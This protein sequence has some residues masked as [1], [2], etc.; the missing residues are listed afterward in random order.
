MIDETLPEVVK[1]YLRAGHRLE[2]IALD[3]FGRWTHEGI[4]F[5]N[6]RV[7]DLFSRSV[8]RTDGGTWVLVIP[9]FTYPIEVERTGYFVTGVDPE[10]GTIELSDG[11][12]ELLDVSTLDYE[13]E[14]C[15]YCKV[16]GGE[17]EA[18]FLRNPYYA[19]ADRLEDHDG[20]IQLRWR[21]ELLDASWALKAQS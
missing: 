8:Q 5:E 14:G 10:V 11:T 19:L 1:S 20:T 6:P 7:I 4:D 21:A 16:K 13:G 2:R 9:P 3:R 15:L 18:R 12:R 17:F